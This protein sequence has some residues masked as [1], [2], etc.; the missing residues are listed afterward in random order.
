VIIKSWDDV[1]IDSEDP[2]LF[3]NST[4]PHYSNH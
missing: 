1:N 3:Q 2:D 4:E